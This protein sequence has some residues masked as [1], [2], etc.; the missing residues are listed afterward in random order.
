MEFVPPL[1]QLRKMSFRQ[2][3]LLLTRLFSRYI[4]KKDADSMG[5]VKCFTCDRVAHWSEMQCGHYASRRNMCTKFMEINNHVQ[6]PICNESY[7]GNLNKYA[8]LLD[9]KYGKG[10]AEYIT[11][12]SHKTCKFMRS[13]MV[14]L[15]LDLEKRMEEYG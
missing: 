5:R 7:H 1:Y 11:E 2:L 6:C 8:K 4:R 12:L 13:D 9:Q 10:T 3:D 15:I 14:E